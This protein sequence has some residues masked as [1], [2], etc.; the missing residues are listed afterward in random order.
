MTDS[1][2]RRVQ[3]LQKTRMLYSEKQSIPAVHPRYRA[4]YRE[5]YGFEEE[6]RQSG[7]NGTLGIR[8]FISLLIFALFVAADYQGIEYAEVDSTKIVREIERKIEFH[9]LP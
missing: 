9:S 2:R 6:Q 5:L 1:E 8:I 3:L 7:R 4:A